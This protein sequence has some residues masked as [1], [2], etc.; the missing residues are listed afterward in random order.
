MNIVRHLEDCW[1]SRSC[2]YSLTFKKTGALLS[3]LSSGGRGSLSVRN[4]ILS[5]KETEGGCLL[6]N[7]HFSERKMDNRQGKSAMKETEK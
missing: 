2:G 3:S 7:S 5:L 1:P 6:Q 4:A